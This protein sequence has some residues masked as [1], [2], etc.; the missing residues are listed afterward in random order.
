MPID[1]GISAI[2][3]PPAE[4]PA[5]VQCATPICGDT[6]VPS[7]DAAATFKGNAVLCV[8]GSSNHCNLQG[9]LRESLNRRGQSYR[10]QRRNKR[11]RMGNKTADWEESEKPPR[12][13]LPMRARN[14][15]G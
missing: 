15:R 13:G 11:A 10:N 3:G 5:R 7:F 2:G 12:E 1:D 9:S 14:C 8:H 4:A 6:H